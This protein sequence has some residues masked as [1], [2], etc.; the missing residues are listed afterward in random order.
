MPKEPYR[1]LRILLLIFSLLAAGAGLLLIFG[2]KPLMVRMFLH[3]PESE[4]STLLLAIV[5]EMGG[6][7]L[8]LGLLFYFASR[9]PVRNV[10]IVDA[11]IVGL[12]ILAFTGLLSL[13]ALDLGRLYPAYLIWG[14]SGVR[15][16]LAALLWYLRPRDA[17]SAGS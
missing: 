5:K 7:I 3:P 12:C 2:D 10:A 14:R 15:L 11:L 1:A 17:L 16:A 4:L 9:D 6:F 13:Y 8:M